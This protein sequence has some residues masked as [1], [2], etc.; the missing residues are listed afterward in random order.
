MLRRQECLNTFGLH[1]GLFMISKINSSCGQIKLFGSIRRCTLN[2]LKVMMRKKVITLTSS[3][4][5]SNTFHFD[6]CR[7]RCL[8][9]SSK[10]RVASQRTSQ[11]FNIYVISHRNMDF[12]FAEWQKLTPNCHEHGK[13][14]RPFI[15]EQLAHLFLSIYFNTTSQ[16]NTEK[17][18]QIIVLFILNTQYCSNVWVSK[19]S[20]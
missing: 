17:H 15:V 9:H 12:I 19:I 13:S 8:F 14:H 2:M 20:F 1:L 16:D 10:N 7:A 4:H 6:T 18:W 3:S 5:Q 11:Y